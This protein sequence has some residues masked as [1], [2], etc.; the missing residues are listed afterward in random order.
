[1][2]L[3][4]VNITSSKKLRIKLIRGILAGIQSKIGRFFPPYSTQNFK[5]K[6]LKLDLRYSGFLRSE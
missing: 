2:T 1:M 6:I 4:Y 5:I 3:K